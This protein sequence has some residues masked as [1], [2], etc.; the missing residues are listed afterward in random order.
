MR[1]PAVRVTVAGRL[2]M[3]HFRNS[4]PKRQRRQFDASVLD[5]MAADSGFGVDRPSRQ[6]ILMGSCVVCAYHRWSAE[7][8]DDSAARKAVGQSIMTFANRTNRMMIGLWYR[9]SKDP[10]ETTRR[11]CAQTIG[12]AYGA[13]FDIAY[14]E[15]PDGF[16][17]VVTVC[18]YRTFLA[19]HHA[20][21]LLDLFC[22]WD[23]VWIDSLP[24]DIRF[25][26]PST[27]A[28]GAQTCRFEFRR[29]PGRAGDRK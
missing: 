28:Q 29:E 2:M 7:G 1:N 4:L 26:R 27:I 25:A 12:R 14:V 5:L 3:R 11:Y 24:K 9:F 6:H 16:V 8:L 22:E 17:S 21:H 15:M 23:R 20:E 19:R 18:G 10:F 13:V